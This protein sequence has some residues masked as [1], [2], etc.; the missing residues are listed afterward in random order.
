MATV[1]EI[2]F[3]HLH[4]FLMEKLKQDMTPDAV[5][6]FIPLIIKELGELNRKET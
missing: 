4:G 1:K 2:E 3:E 5:D 6:K